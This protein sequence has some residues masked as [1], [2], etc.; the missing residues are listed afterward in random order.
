M[1]TLSLYKRFYLIYLISEDN[2]EAEL[3]KKGETN[4]YSEKAEV[5]VLRVRVNY[6]LFSIISASIND[7]IASISLSN[8]GK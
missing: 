5:L 7:N 3:K 6:C 4:E 1:L 8:M 2:E